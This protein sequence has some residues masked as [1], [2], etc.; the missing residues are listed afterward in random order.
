M[1][2]NWGEKIRNHLRNEVDPQPAKS[3]WYFENLL[4]RKGSSSGRQI[5]NTNAEISYFSKS[6]ITW[7]ALNTSWPRTEK[8]NTYVL[9]V[10]T[11]VL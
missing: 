11:V 6:V 9:R 10:C 7:N 8:E 2:S 3:I 1:Q 4:D 5:G